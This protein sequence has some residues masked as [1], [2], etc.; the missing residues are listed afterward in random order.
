MDLLVCPRM[1]K[2]GNARTRKSRARHYIKYSM[3]EI[4]SSQSSQFLE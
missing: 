3:H 1:G 4:K 2:L